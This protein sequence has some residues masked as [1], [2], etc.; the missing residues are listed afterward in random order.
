VTLELSQLRE[1]L[2]FTIGKPS[3][4]RVYP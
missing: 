1:G 2:F 4:S 3:M